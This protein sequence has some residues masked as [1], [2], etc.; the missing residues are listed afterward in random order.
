MANEENL[1]RF[2]KDKPT[3]TPEEAK[4]NGKK[5]GI[6]SGEARRKSKQMKAVL[7]YLMEKELD[8]KDGTKGT[9]LEAI[10]TAM[11]KEAMAGNVKATVFIRDTMGQMPETTHI[12][13]G[14]EGLSITVE[15]PKHKEMLEDL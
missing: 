10:C 5:G 6:A 3:S 4:K 11:V 8:R 1:K 13:K 14:E 9:T 12:L 7:E 15:D 2:G